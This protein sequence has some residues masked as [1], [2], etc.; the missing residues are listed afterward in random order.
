MVNGK[1]QIKELTF[2]IFAVL[3]SEQS[4][5]VPSSHYLSDNQKA[6]PNLQEESSA[7]E[8]K[9]NHDNDNVENSDSQILMK[10]QSAAQFGQ[11]FKNSS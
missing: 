7:Q 9:D 3:S 2:D 1:G 5:M 10:S 4:I 6:S 8:D 11:S